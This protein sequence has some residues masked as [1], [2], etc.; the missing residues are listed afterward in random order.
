MD[1]VRVDEL[2]EG[3]DGQVD[4]YT[5]SQDYKYKLDGPVDKLHQHADKLYVDKDNELV[6]GMEGQEDDLKKDEEEHNFL[7]TIFWTLSHNI[8]IEPMKVKDDAD[9]EIAAHANL[10]E[11]MEECGGGTD[12]N[13]KDDA[14]RTYLNNTNLLSKRIVNAT[15][16]V[17]AHLQES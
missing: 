10:E 8:G 1:E 6:D 4:T 17:E 15:I 13:V 5:V 12:V 11:C 2:A 7:G 16:S 3:L 9:W 14:M